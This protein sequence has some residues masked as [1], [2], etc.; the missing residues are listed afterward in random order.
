M[1]KKTKEV[2][3]ACKNSLENHEIA[4]KL[5]LQ[6]ASGGMEIFKEK[7]IYWVKNDLLYK[8][9]PDNFK[10]DFDN[11]IVYLTDLKS[12]AFNVG[13][14]DGTFKYRRIYRQI[15]LY[16][17]GIFE[18]CLAN[19]IN[20]SEWKWEMNIVAVETKDEFRTAVF[21]VNDLWVF[22]GRDEYEALVARVLFHKQH[23]FIKSME[24]YNNNGYM[25]LK[26]PE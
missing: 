15:A 7:N 24:E 8:I 20:I 1:T 11:K 17:K 21:P 18:Y 26:N 13:N 25:L 22:K 6:E 10:L 2:V 14:F 16:K 3:E 23:G 19:N 9:K 4:T 12:G 5:L